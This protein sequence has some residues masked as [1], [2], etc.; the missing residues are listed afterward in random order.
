MEQLIKNPSTDKLVDEPIVTK[1]LQERWSP[2]S[3]SKEPIAPTDL[4]RIFEAGATAMSSFNEQPWNI[5]LTHK[6]DPTYEKLFHCLSEYNQEWVHFAPVLGAVIAKKY[7]TKS[8]KENRHRFYD[9]GA[10]M[11]YASLQASELGYQIH[12]M[13]GFSP[14]KLMMDLKI[15]H[16]YE[17]ATMFVI[18]KPDSP[19]KLPVN[20][21]KQEQEEQTRKE[22][23]SFIFADKW[24][25]P[26]HF[27]E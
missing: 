10:F 27:D 22:V 16:V 4:R 24:G 9:S 5:I 2:R 1:Y 15:P 3:F 17:A 26:Y 21:R 13:A 25:D 7:F 14:G 8:R 23:S 6:G 19:E 18:G 11:A 20:L 12:Q